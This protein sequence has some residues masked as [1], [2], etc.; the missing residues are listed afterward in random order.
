MVTGGS[1]GIGKAIAGRLAAKGDE[2]FIVGR[3]PDKGRCAVQALRAASRHDRV[4]FLQADL[5]LMRD[6]ARLAGEIVA[7]IPRLHRL[8]LCAGIVRGRLVLTSEGVESNFATNYLSRFVLAGRLLDLLKRAGMPGAAARVLI[9]G[10][11]VMNGRI[12][13]DDVNLTN[14][15]GIVKM[16]P[17]S[18]RQMISS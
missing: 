8:V 7:R 17:H 16:V 6:T 13:Y 1:D 9:I 15:F 12:Y 10:G 4:H 11:A 3:D 14:N 2:V 5:S 18:A